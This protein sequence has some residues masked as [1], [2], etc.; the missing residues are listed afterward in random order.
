M[1]SFLHSHSHTHTHFEIDQD[2]EHENAKILITKSEKNCTTF[3]WFTALE[4][5][6]KKL[7]KLKTDQKHVVSLLSS[8]IRLVLIVMQWL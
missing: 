4:Y 5:I 8:H 7:L 3:N 1:V 2:Y 6:K